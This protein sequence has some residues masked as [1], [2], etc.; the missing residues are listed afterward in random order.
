M[1]DYS[2]RDGGFSL[3]ELMIALVVSVIVAGAIF[4]LLSGGKSAFRREPELSD[5][6]QN[7]RIAMATI[8][9]DVAR[10]GLNLPPFVQAFSDALDG[11]GPTGANG[12]ASDEIEILA[13]TDCL[14]LSVCA[15]TG[16]Q[17]TTWEAL[18]QCLTLPTLIAA[19][20]AT[21]AGV[22]WANPAT[23]GPTACP[24]TP[25]S[26]SNGNVVL[27]TGQPRFSGPSGGL[28]F[29]P[30]QMAPI[31]VVR[32]R[33]QVDADG[34]P[35]LWRSEFGGEPVN[36]QPSWQ[37][38]A[39]GIEDLQFS[40]LNAAGW[41]ARPGIVACSMTPCTAPTQADYDKI[42]RQ[43]RVTVQARAMGVALQGQTTSAAGGDAVRG[44]LQQEITPRAALIA[45]T[46]AGT[47][48]WY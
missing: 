12:P 23:G 48:R 42:I 47:G 46:G 27:A 3:I 2:R 33:I 40:Y 19:W 28:T 8:N 16:N 13:P 35:N 41:Q 25:A 34:T 14:S 38:V 17:V 29:T 31:S 22:Y 36:G 44:Q 32:Y 20:D 1:R 5:R 43:V 18:P 9:Q 30:A 39:R 10:A 26:T 37:L 6:Q 15:A 4:G 45:L 7:I 21:E 11:T 24:S